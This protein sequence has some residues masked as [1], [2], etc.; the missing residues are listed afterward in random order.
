MLVSWK[1]SIRKL[2]MAIEFNEIA[3]SGTDDAF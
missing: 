1:K 2:N 3:L